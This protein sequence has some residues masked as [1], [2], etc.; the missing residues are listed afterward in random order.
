MKSGLIERGPDNLGPKEQIR[1]ISG[2]VKRLVYDQYKCW[3]EQI[4]PGLKDEQVIF[5]DYK[6]LTRPEKKW[7]ENYFE[8]QVFPVL[9]PLAIDPAHPFP[10]LTNKALYI[11]AT[12]DDPE[13]R[14]I[15][16][17]MAIIPVPR[18]LPRIVKIEVSRRGEPDVYIFLS[19]II[20]RFIKR[21]FPG[22]RVRYAVPFR[23]TRNSD[24]YIDEEE[25]ENLL[26][27]MEE[28][29][30]NREKGAAV[31]LEI[32]KGA[33]PILLQEL[34]DAIGLKPENVQTIDGPINLL[35]LMSAY[36]LSD[37]PDLKFTPQVPMV[38]TELSSPERIFDSIRAKDRLLYHPYESFQPFIDFIS[39]AANDPN[40]Y[41]IKQALYRT[42]G[43]P[44][45]RS[46]DGRIPQRETGHRLG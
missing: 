35:R 18:V 32:A 29:L 27:H 3:S 21:L 2:I 11:F 5:S 12:V 16:S 43:S 45:R 37:R 9:T 46:T 41:A 7:V 23:I 40:V 14:L 13:T 22:Y 10:Q 1:R 25:A 44:Y 20:Q 33:D 8:E 26:R 34:I 38:P 19:D 42:S 6:D 30:M 4:V 24:L 39:Q 36:D 17:L 31:R 28:E 15:E